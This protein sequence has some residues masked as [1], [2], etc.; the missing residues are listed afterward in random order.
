MFKLKYILI[1]IITT[2]TLGI[3]SIAYA[4][5]VKIVQWWDEYF[6]QK[7]EQSS[8]SYRYSHEIQAQSEQDVDNDGIYDDVVVC[9]AFSMKEPFNPYPQCQSNSKNHHRYRIDRP[10]AKFYGGVV[11]RYTNVSH[12]TEINSKDE[13]LLIFRKYSQ[14]SVQ[15][16]EGAKPSLY[17]IKYPNNVQRS[18]AGNWGLGWADI[19]VWPVVHDWTPIDKIYSKTQ[20][21]EVNF[22]TIFMWKKENFVNGGASSQMISFDNTSKIAVDI[23]RTRDNVEECRF[24]VQD[25][26]NFWISEYAAGASIFGDDPATVELNPLK[27]RWAIYTPSD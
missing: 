4:E 5:S 1:Y 18:G 9:Q 21:A 2:I 17:N 13:E 20:D 23:T 8:V 15:P 3:N 11:A 27:S 16:V 10:S 24:I 26:E 12:L 14:A 19:T 22:T 6:P 25:N 7:F